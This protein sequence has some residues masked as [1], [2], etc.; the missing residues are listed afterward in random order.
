MCG[1]DRVC[2]AAYLRGSTLLFVLRL[3]NKLVHRATEFA[4]HGTQALLFSYAVG[5]LFISR[6]AVS[7]RK[8]GA[9]RTRHSFGY[10]FMDFEIQME[11][12]SAQV[13]VTDPRRGG[14]L[15]LSPLLFISHSLR[16]V[17]YFNQ[18]RCAFISPFFVVPLASRKPTPMV[19]VLDLGRGWGM[20]YFFEQKGF[21][22]S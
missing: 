18:I 22:V 2:I 1:C 9:L 5:D 15:L 6:Q 13:V 7:V 16:L 17:I 4:L 20:V 8:R 21:A 19:P 14:G 3:R 11:T 12:S 10:W